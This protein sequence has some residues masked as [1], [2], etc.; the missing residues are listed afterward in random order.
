MLRCIRAVPVT[1]P[2][3]EEKELHWARSKTLG[4]N[5]KLERPGA[6]IQFLLGKR[7]GGLFS[8]FVGLFTWSF[9]E[10]K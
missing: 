9:F 5:R 7:L 6:V 8:I 2:W 1:A 3:P 4:H 10:T